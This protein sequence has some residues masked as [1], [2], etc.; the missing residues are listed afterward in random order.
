MRKPFVLPLVTGALLAGC[1]PVPTGPNVLVLPGD[2]KTLGQFQ[3]DDTVC[4]QW[5]LQ[6][7]GAVTPSKASSE[8][9]ATGAAIGTVLGAAGGA[10]IGAASG[11][12]ATGAAVGSGIGLLGGTAVGADNAQGHGWTIQ[13]RYDAAYVQCMY[14]RGNQIPVPRGSAPAARVAGN[15]AATSRPP[16]IPPPPAGIPPAPPLGPAR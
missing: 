8:S 3:G 5:A 1:I 16:G 9:T 4:R 15:A 6:Q 10:A 13:S 7:I 14:V 11:N 12:P 2:R